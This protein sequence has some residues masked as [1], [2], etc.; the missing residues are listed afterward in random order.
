MSVVCFEWVL[1]SRRDFIFGGEHSTSWGRGGRWG[2]PEVR[3]SRNECSG[4]EG[5]PWGSRNRGKAL[6]PRAAIAL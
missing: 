1:I 6:F 4:A 5:S 3:M 2:V